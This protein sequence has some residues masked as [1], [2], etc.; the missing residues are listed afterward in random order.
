VKKSYIMQ[1]GREIWA[2]VDE[3]NVS[4]LEAQKLNKL[5]KQK[6]EENLDYP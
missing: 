6:V 4:D 3:E 1:A 2:F 5:I